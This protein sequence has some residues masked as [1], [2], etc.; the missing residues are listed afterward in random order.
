MAR[1]KEREIKG[2][3]ERERSRRRPTSM[4]RSMTMHPRARVLWGW[5]CC[6]LVGGRK[7]CEEDEVGGAQGE[8]VGEGREDQEQVDE[9]V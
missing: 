1:T 5:R 2:S 3:A 9:Q 4:A 8:G 6:R 7:K